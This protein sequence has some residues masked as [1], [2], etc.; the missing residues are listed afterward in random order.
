MGYFK[1]I[2]LRPSVGSP[3]NYDPY[4][5][6]ILP[7]MAEHHH[8]YL[9]E[10]ESHNRSRQEMIES[11]N[12]QLLGQ[13]SIVI[14]IVGLFIPF[15]VENV[16]SLNLFIKIILVSTFVFVLIHYVLSIFHSGKNF[17]VNKFRYMVGNTSTVTKANR[18]TSEIDFINEQNVDLVQIIHN[19]VIIVNKKSNNLIYA[20]RCFKIA[21]ISFTVFTLII[22]GLFFSKD[23]KTNEVK[24]TNAQEFKCCNDTIVQK[25]NQINIEQ[26]N[27]LY[28]NLINSRIDSINNKLDVL[29]KL[30]VECKKKPQKAKPKNPC[31]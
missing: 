7:K 29:I 3:E 31:P 20:S 21:N 1:Y 5:N 9:Q 30:Q 24:V 18:A 23:S 4:V 13:A 19:N 15:F 14:S 17:E 2:G 12:S 28:I 11:K 10:L 26:N 25:S 16:S 6:S 22:L 27:Q 8:K